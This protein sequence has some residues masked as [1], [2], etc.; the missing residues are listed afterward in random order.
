MS[1]GSSRRP[2]EIPAEQFDKNWDQ[3]FGKRKSNDPKTP[4]DQAKP[5]K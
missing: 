5:N 1:K 4:Q 3:I 2:K